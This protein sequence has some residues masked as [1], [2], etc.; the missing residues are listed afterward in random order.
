MANPPCNICNPDK[1]WSPWRLFKFTLDFGADANSYSSRLHNILGHNDELIAGKKYT[2]AWP[3]KSFQ[4]YTS[5][6][7]TILVDA[8]LQPRSAYYTGFW[9]T[10]LFLVSELVLLPF[11]ALGFF[12]DFHLP[13]RKP[14][15]GTYP[16]RS[17][18]T[19]TAQNNALEVFEM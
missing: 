14:I 5:S 9:G 13:F 10:S 19:F 12:R 18:P 7:G 15:H 17:T 8:Y 6:N 16:S 11:R 4:V 1:Y 2:S 3:L